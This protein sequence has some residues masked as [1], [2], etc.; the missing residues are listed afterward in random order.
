MVNMKPN[1]LSRDESATIESVID[2]THH[3]S[4]DPTHTQVSNIFFHSSVMSVQTVSE[5]WDIFEIGS[6]DVLNFFEMSKLEQH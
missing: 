1:I 3:W 4:M 6:D 5:S 2:H